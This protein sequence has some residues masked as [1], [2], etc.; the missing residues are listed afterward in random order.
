M[1]ENYWKKRIADATLTDLICDFARVP[2]HHQ[3]EAAQHISGKID[4]Y[5][6]Q[7]KTAFIQYVCEEE[8]GVQS[9]SEY[10]LYSLIENDTTFD[11]LTSIFPGPQQPQQVFDEFETTWLAND[12]MSRSIKTFELKSSSKNVR[13]M[14]EIVCDLCE[15]EEDLIAM[16]NE[17][18]VIK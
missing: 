14:W 6:Y 15:D 1:Q 2:I 10:D 7:I 16:G 5:L 12:F 9:I 8:C 18:F 3:V 17:L 11:F 4:D 13:K